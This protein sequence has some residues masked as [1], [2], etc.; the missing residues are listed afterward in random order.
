[1][2]SR[3]TAF[4][5]KGKDFDIPTVATQLNVAYILEGS[6]RKAGNQIRI[7]AQL[8]EARSDTHLWSETYD[9]KLDDIFA[10]QDEISAAIIGALKERL[11]LQSGVVPQMIAAANT[12]A[13]DAYLR[14]RYLVVQRTKATIEGAVREFEKAIML[15]PDYALAHAELT[16]ATMMLARYLYGDLTRADASA[17]AKPHAERAMALAPNLAEA[18]AAAGF[19]VVASGDRRIT[20]TMEEGLTYFER[21]IQ[22]N[23]SYAIIYAWMAQVIDYYSGN[24]TRMFAMRETALRLDPLSLPIISSYFNSLYRRNRLDEFDR[25]LEKIVSIHPGTYA[26][27]RGYRMAIGGKWAHVVLGYLD[28]LEINPEK[29]GL[30]ASLARFLADLGLEK[31]VFAISQD[32]SPYLLIKLGKPGDAVKTQEARLADDPN[33]F[34]ARSHL[35]LILALAGDYA[36]ARPILEDVWQRGGERVTM[37]GIFPTGSA[38]ALIAIRRNA[39]E[40]SATEELVAAIRDNVGRYHEAGITGATNEFSVNYEAGLAAYLAGEHEKG[41]ALIAQGAEDGYFIPLNEAYLQTL[42][43]DPG[44]APIRAAQEARQARERDRFLTIVCTDNPYEA[45]WQPVKG[46]CETFAAEGMVIE[47]HSW[48]AGPPSC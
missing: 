41:L 44:F 7:T 21:A 20:E 22:I 28:A 24:Y 19:L 23:P 6:V 5:F 9:R 39:G 1:M 35:G 25:E 18:Q 34:N 2:I 38:A 8:I 15:D 48:C 42:Y 29:G 27:W 13:H 30:R 37:T 33:N 32:P 40:E 17:R 47:P 16:I 14:G 10:V 36:R 3:Y 45:V 11:D 26:I 43:D 31:E 12:E 4:S 46:T